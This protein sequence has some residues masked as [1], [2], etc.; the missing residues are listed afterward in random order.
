PARA[1]SCRGRC[2]RPCRRSEARAPRR[3]PLPAG[4]AGLRGCLTPLTARCSPGPYYSYCA[5]RPR[6]VSGARGPRDSGLAQVVLAR[7]ELQTAGR[8]QLPPLRL[9]TLAPAEQRQDQ[10]VEPLR[11]V[12]LVPVR[13]DRV[14]DQQSRVRRRRCPDRV[15]DRCRALVAP[16]VEDRREDVDVALGDAL[17]EVALDERDPAAER[18]FVAH[19]LG[20]VVDDPAESRV[21]TEHARE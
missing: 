20:E 2:G 7:D 3:H 9:V 21:M 17:E 16:V 13:D 10:E 15:E 18:V 14:D 6:T 5:L 19:G 12:R 11:S 1:T 4:G 8:E